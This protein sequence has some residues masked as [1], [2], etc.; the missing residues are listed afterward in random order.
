MLE[1]EEIKIT[2]IKAKKAETWG[3]V[4]KGHNELN[5]I[6]KEE[7]QK[8][9]LLERFGEEHVGFDFSDAEISGNVPDPKNFMGGMKND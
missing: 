1:E 2:L 3:A 8:K 4:F 7:V 6:Q 9:L 5:P